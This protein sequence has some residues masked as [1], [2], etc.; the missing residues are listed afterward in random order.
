MAHA[1]ALIGFGL[2]GVF[3]IWCIVATCIE[4]PVLPA[5]GFFSRLHSHWILCSHPNYGEFRKY[6]VNIWDGK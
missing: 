2:I 5:R 1:L 6:L 3:A 4:Q